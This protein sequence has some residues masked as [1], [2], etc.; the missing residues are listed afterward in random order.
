MKRQFPIPTRQC[1][2]HSPL[3]LVDDHDH[4]S[5]GAR[6]ARGVRALCV[7][8][9]L[10]TA[11]LALGCRGHDS[12]SNAAGS[13]ARLHVFAGIPPLGWL[14]QRIG[15]PCVEV[16]VLV[17]PGQNPH[18]F[19]PSP[20]Q[21]VAMEKASMFFKIGM[22]FESDL[23]EKIAARH[24]S[25]TLVDVSQGIVKRRMIEECDE[26]G[27][28]AS[29]ADNADQPGGPDPHV[30]LTPGNLK[31][32]AANV[33]DALEKTCPAHAGE[34]RRNQTAL[35]QKLDAL[36]ARIRRRGPPAAGRRSTCS[37][38]RWVT[39]PTPTA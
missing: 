6:G 23:V 7:T 3:P 22:P 10:A 21:V 9:L 11:F 12:A 15:G 39:L 32:M 34:F 29:R 19:E 28:Q 20:R 18:V 8:A 31:I 27:E 17:Q 38:R 37:T 24:P 1:H 30:W 4:A 36:D 14:V 2:K 26:P 5:H 35:N 13:P 25:L 33:A 16:R